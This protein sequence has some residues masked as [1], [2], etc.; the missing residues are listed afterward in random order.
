MVPRLKALV[1]LL[2]LAPLAWLVYGA[3]NSLLGANPI[4]YITRATGDW[5]LRLLLLSLAITPLRRLTGWHPLIRFRRLLGLFAFFYAV[6]H[7][8]TYLWFD[9][10]FDLAEILKDIQKRPFIT[11]GVA[12][13]LVLVPLA[14]TS[15]AGWIR[16][17]GRYWQPLHRAVYLAA[18]LGI[19]H[20][21][22]LV[23]ADRR[24]PLTYAALLAALLLARLIRR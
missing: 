19:L 12:A 3:F 1:W 20:Y 24:G 2:S 22:W 11:V 9:K 23:K 15:T 4:E 7:L 5:T 18:G 14:V 6:L 8:L 13:L 10:F 17:L 21:L 16:R